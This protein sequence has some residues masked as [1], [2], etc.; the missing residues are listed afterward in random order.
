[1]GT[2][3]RPTP[4]RLPEKLLQLRKFLGL[5]QDQMAE[6]L[7][8]V[9]SPPQPAHISRFEAGTREPSLLCLLEI[10]RLVP[11]VTLEQLL[12]DRLELHL[13]RRSPAN[14]RSGKRQTTSRDKKR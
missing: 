5:T 6:R 9:P 14:V 12:D 11:G 4:A 1:M 3:K 10:S 8:D 2:R 7:K 13:S